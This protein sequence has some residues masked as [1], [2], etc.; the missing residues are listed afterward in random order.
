LTGVGRTGYT[1]RGS[2]L[3]M[4]GDFN[5]ALGWCDRAVHLCETKDLAIWLPGAYAV[6]GWTLAWAG[7]A[8]K[9]LPYLERAPA[10]FDRLGIR[11]HLSLLHAYWA[12]GLLLAGA[13][14]EARAIADRALVLAIESGEAG[15]EAEIQRLQGDIAAAATP[16]DVEAAC[17][18]YERA[19]ATA[20]ALGLAPLRARCRLGRGLVLRRLGRPDQAR[21]D[22][23]A[24]RAQFDELGMAYWRDRA[25][26]ALDA[27][28]R[29]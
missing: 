23:E 24:A 29:S 21:E 9:G 6:W 14:A 13:P 11:T 18:A 19:A 12:E 1:Y 28:G 8:A 4:R 25:R 20:E 26:H 27:P 5:E 17:A 2:I 22:L 10:L 3:T 15:H 16:A 7:Q